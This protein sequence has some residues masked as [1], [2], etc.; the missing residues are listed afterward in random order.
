LV[1]APLILIVTAVVA[2][3]AKKVVSKYWGVYTDLGASFLENLRGLT[4]LKIYGADGAA[5][6]RMDADAEAF[7]GATMKVLGVQLSSLTAMD[8]VAFGGAAAGIIVAVLR[9][10]AGAID[11]W[12]CL[13]VAL[14]AAEF[15]IPVRLIGS[16]FHTAMNGVAASEKIFAI[17]DLPEAADTGH[18][19]DAAGESVGVSVAGLG[20]SYGRDCAPALDGVDLRLG[21]NGMTALVGESG[22]GKSTLAKIIAGTITGYTGSA[23]LETRARDK[24][25]DQSFGTVH[26]D[27]GAGAMGTVAAGDAGATVAGAAGTT[28]V[29]D[30]GTTGVGT[31]GAMSA[32]VT[33]LGA[34]VDTFAVEL[35]DIARADLMRNVT[36]V[37]SNSHIFTGSVRDNLVMA[38]PEATDAEMWTALRAARL[39]DFLAGGAGLETRVSEDASNLSGGQR[40]RLA[41]ARALMRDSSVYVF[42]EATSNIDAESEGLIMETIAEL[43]RAKTVL[44][45]SHRLANVTEAHMIYVMESGR[46]AEAGTHGELLYRGGLYARMYGAQMDLESAAFT[47]VGSGMEAANG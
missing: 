8:L 40:Q 47:D 18:G 44:M 6:R 10:A 15:F 33:S 32:T 13:A 1:C 31:A 42:D 14:L 38:K 41:I 30:V 16:Y 43:A 2:R 23:R 46:I 17:L 26:P 37:G 28:G 4:T 20:F 29:G 22:C 25:V 45:I 34:T 11:L 5:A 7:R 27:A 24:G 39:A 9:Y 36:L 19:F 12:G 3:T 35:N 21:E